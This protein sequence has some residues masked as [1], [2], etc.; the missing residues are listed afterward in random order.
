MQKKNEANFVG[1]LAATASADTLLHYSTYLDLFLHTQR[2]LYIADSA[3]AKYFSKQLLPQ[4]KADLKELKAFNE[5]HQSPLEPQPGP[6]ILPVDGTRVLGW[7]RC[8]KPGTANPR[9]A[10]QC[11]VQHSPVCPHHP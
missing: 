3:K 1:Y 10:R 8:P 5:A 11:S 4:V 9:S 6:G 2:N 7:C